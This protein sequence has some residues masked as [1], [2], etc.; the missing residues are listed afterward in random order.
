M[1]A[2]PTVVATVFPSGLNATR[3]IGP[4]KA[5]DRLA[6][7]FHGAGGAGG[8]GGCSADVIGGRR[9]GAGG[10]AWVV[11]V[12]GGCAGGAAGVVGAGWLAGEVGREFGCAAR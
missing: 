5:L 6:R 12:R 10:C 7:T 4:T 11:G 9:G 8:G 1:P 2:P 3:K